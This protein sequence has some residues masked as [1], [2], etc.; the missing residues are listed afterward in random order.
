MIFSIAAKT[1]KGLKRLSNEDNLYVNGQYL[2]SPDDSFDFSVTTHDRG[3]FAVCDG[4]GGESRGDFASHCAVSTLGRYSDRILCIDNEAQLNAVDEYIQDVNAALCSESKK[5]GVRI[6]STLAM[7]CL[8]DD[9]ANAYNIGDSR[10]YLFRENRLVQLSLDHTATQQKVNLG[11][12]KESEALYDSDRNKLTQHFGVFEDEFILEAHIASAE[13]QAGDVFLICSDGLTDMLKKDEIASI[14]NG[15]I[16]PKKISDVLM[17]TAL[18]NGGNDNISVIVIG[19]LHNAYPPSPLNVE[20][21]VANQNLAEPFA[22]GRIK[23]ACDKWQVVTQKFCC[24]ERWIHT[25]LMI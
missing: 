22:Y 15:N 1:E 18:E 11:I 3:I 12:I 10:I 17:Q 24:R 13:I 6:G 19:A 23:K 2:Q 9:M 8:K 14:L 4:M 5:N 20:K 16:D 7:L 21:G 25:W